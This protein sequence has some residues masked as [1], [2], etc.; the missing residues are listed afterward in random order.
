MLPLLCLL[1]LSPAEGGRRKRV[2]P[3][4]EPTP[5]PAPVLD[6]NPWFQGLIV[7]LGELPVG[8]ANPTAIGCAACHQAPFAAWQRGPHGGPPP[9]GIASL[10]DEP[11]CTGCHLPL[12]EQRPIAGGFG[13]GPEQPAALPQPFSATLWSE[14]VGCAACH[15]RGGTILAA[16]DA[17][18]SPHPVLGSATLGDEEGCATCHQLEVD[19]V[20]WYDTY[21]SW[22]AS[23]YKEAGV[24]C[25]DCHAPHGQATGPGVTL[26]VDVSARSLT[27]GGAPL[28]VSVVLQNTGAGHSWPSTGPH[29]GAEL[30]VRLVGPVDSKLGP[31]E[32]A[33]FTSPL[34]RR[35]GPDGQLADDTR[36]APMGSASFRVDVALDQDAPVGPWHLEVAVRR[37]SAAAPLP[38]GEPSEV[39]GPYLDASTRLWLPLAMD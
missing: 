34:A 7:P 37:T 32:A 11:A 36:I 10:S 9:T 39:D 18:A 5:P 31:T 19:G 13:F 27:R 26:L 3:V 14:G 12:V 4:P 38:T 33:R 28:T 8:L 16:S 2:E 29:S 6:A 23:P 1:L 24:G 30:V 15:L 25:A 22:S 20:P 21:Q 35:L 17:D